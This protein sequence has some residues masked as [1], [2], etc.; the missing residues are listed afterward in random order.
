MNRKI[1][2]GDAIGERKF[3]TNTGSQDTK[4]MLLDSESVGDFYSPLRGIKDPPSS[5]ALRKAPLASLKVEAPLTPL[6]SE[7]PPPWQRRDVT[8]KEGLREVIASIPSPIASSKYLSSE[9]FDTFISQTIAPIAAKAERGIEQEQLQEA[10]TM[11]R[12]PVPVMDLS[13]PT[14]PWKGLATI[15]GVSDGKDNVTKQLLEMKNSHFSKHHWPGVGEMERSL[16]W[17]PFP[18]ALGHVE[19]YETIGDDGMTEISISV[20]ECMDS[21]TL[22]WKPEGLRLFDDLANTEEELETGDFPEAK[23]IESLVKKRKREL[24]QELEEDTGES[25][26]NTALWATTKRKPINHEAFRK[27]PRLSP[28]MSSRPKE[29]KDTKNVPGKQG[30]VTT[31][32]FS[33]LESLENFMSLRNKGPVTSKLTAEHHFPEQKSEAVAQQIVQKDPHPVLPAS[34]PASHY[35]N[36]SRIAAPQFVVPTSPMPFVVST[37]FLRNR[38]LARHIQRL[39]PT[40]E[41][42]ERDFTLHS[43]PKM[44]NIKNGSSN[45]AHADM[46]A[47][48]ADIILSPS[49]GLI[50]TTL[51]MIKQRSLPGQAAKSAL[52][53]RITRVAPRYERLIVIITS[54]NN[55]NYGPDR[56]SEP[57]ISAVSALDQND[58]EALIDFTSFCA[59]VLEE[60]QV[61]LAKGDTED[62]AQWIA[63]LMTKH[64]IQDPEVKLLQDETLWEIFL[65]RVGM[66][67]FAAQVILSELKAPPDTAQHKKIGA[68]EKDT[69]YGLTAFVKMSLQERLVRFELLLGGRRILERVSRVLDARW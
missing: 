39:M 18:A 3:A 6:H 56:A 31:K 41:F 17:M 66:N 51:Q 10:D 2:E 27:V 69:D 4:S 57:T 61:I 60:T 11:Y 48:E 28:R 12:V 16:Q 21:S 42:I 64:C 40:A 24:Q 8:H 13:L 52:R 5:P 14:A 36:P 62:L 7:Q 22:T 50:L 34:E 38:K 53:E 46:V 43:A 19:T 65:R 59:S 37:V 9:D 58:C 15:V 32:P 67:A 23:D 63:S 26:N 47:D 35:V 45:E 33:A 25:G 20:P 29:T 55:D 44:A 1:F 49:S 30:T 54:G 68:I